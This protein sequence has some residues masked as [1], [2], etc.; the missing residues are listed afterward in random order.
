MQVQIKTRHEL[1]KLDRASLERAINHL[2][3]LTERY[4]TGHLHVSV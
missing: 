1:S 4:R 2:D 3:R